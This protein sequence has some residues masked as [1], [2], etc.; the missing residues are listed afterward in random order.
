MK[1][2]DSSVSELIKA[3]LRSIKETFVIENEN[4]YNVL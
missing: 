4:E 3:W 1:T 2:T